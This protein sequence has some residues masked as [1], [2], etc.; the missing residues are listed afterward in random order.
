MPPGTPERGHG[1]HTDG[2]SCMNRM[3]SSVRVNL[4]V[5]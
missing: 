5:A 1:R 2:G 4:Q 3:P